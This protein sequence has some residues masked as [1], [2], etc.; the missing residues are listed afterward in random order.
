M[1]HNTQEI[2]VRRSALY[3]L[4]GLVLLLACSSLAF[5]Q[6]ATVVGTVTDPSGAVVANAKPGPAPPH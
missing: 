6:E 2:T 1:K 3:L 5:S 4:V